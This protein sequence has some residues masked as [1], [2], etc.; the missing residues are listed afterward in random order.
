[1][2]L[3]SVFSKKVINDKTYREQEDIFFIEFGALS[4]NDKAVS[5]GR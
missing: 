5:H 2:P 4:C 3:A 1:M